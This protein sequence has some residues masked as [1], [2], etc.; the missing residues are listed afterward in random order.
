MG[1]DTASDNFHIV[2]THQKASTINTEQPRRQKWLGQL[3]L[4]SLQHWA[5]YSWPDGYMNREATMAET[6]ATHGPSSMNLH[7]TK[8]NLT[9]DSSECRTCQQQ[10]PV[11]SPWYGTVSQRPTGHLL[12]SWWRWAPFILERPAVS[13]HRDRVL[14]Q[15]WTR[16]S[17]PRA[18]ASTAVQELR[19]AWS[20]VMENYTT[21]H[22]NR[23]HTSQQGRSC[24]PQDISHTAPSRGSQPDRALHWLSKGA[25]EAPA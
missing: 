13:P 3:T 14:F 7:L 20:M 6:E 25:V 15:V 10:K 19:S 21:W 17:C 11:L 16:L 12:E 8:A 1:V 24:D 23:E 9:S 5:L 18:S 2:N 4:V 22:L